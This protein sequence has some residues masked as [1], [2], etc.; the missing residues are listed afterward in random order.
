MYSCGETLGTDESVIADVHTTPRDENENNVGWVLHCGTGRPNTAIIV[1]KDSSGKE[2]AYVG[3]VFSYYEK[4]TDNYERLTDEKWKSINAEGSR[5]LFTNLFQTDKEG[6]LSSNQENLWMNNSDINYDIPIFDAISKSGEAPFKVQ[7]INETK[8]DY[9]TYK[10]YFGDGDSSSLKNPI[11]LYSKVGVYDVTL[12]VSDYL[13]QNELTVKNHIQVFQN[14]QSSFEL[15]NNIGE[16]PFR[17]DFINKSTGEIKS[18]K[19]YFG[20]GASSTLSNTSHTYTKAGNFTVSLVV[21]DGKTSSTYTKEKF[22]SVSDNTNV[23]SGTSKTETPPFSPNPVKDKLFIQI[24]EFNEVD[25][26]QIIDLKGRKI[27]ETEL[28]G[29]IDVSSLSKGIYFLKIGDKEWKFLKE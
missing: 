26:I 18:N 24:G 11:H 21:S 19:W 15:S 9:K 29:S 7:F 28:K 23:D 25:K 20:D 3:P 27:I 8:G 10:W 22:I 5:P 1:A 6:K 14:L 17:V 4:I 13:F 2:R 12:V 16:A